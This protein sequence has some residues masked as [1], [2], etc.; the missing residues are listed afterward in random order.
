MLAG[1][2]FRSP[3]VQRMELPGGQRDA[4]LRR[5]GPGSGERLKSVEFLEKALSAPSFGAGRRP[6][7]RWPS[8]R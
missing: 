5:W 4:R 6:K 1:V 7:P 3:I 8:A 2:R